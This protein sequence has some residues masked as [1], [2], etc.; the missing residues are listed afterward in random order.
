[1]PN[2]DI[3]FATI[4]NLETGFGTTP[5]QSGDPTT[6][7]RYL[8]NIYDK[9]GYMRDEV[10]AFYIAFILN[11]GS[12]SYAYHIPGRDAV[13]D[14]PANTLT[15][16]WAANNT[17]SELDQ[18]PATSTDLRALSPSNGAVYHFYDTSTYNAS[19]N[20]TST[21]GCRH[22]NFWQNSDEMYPMTDDFETWNA[23]QDL[24][25]NTSNT[26]TDPVTGNVITTSSFDLNRGVNV[27]HHHFPS[28]EN[29]FRRS[30]ISNDSAVNSSVGT[31]STRSRWND[32]L[33]IM[34]DCT[35]TVR[36]EPTAKIRPFRGSC[37][38]INDGNEPDVPDSS[39][40]S[41]SAPMNGS[42]GQYTVQDM[43][44]ALYDFSSG[45]FIADQSMIVRVDWYVAMYKY[46]SAS[47]NSS[48]RTYARLRCTSTNPNNS[49]TGT[50]TV[51]DDSIMNW[52]PNCCN[53]GSTVLQRTD[54]NQAGIRTVYLDPGIHYI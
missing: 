16:T 50:F 48:N 3:F 13:T 44:S 40:S 8:S 18:P 42:Q 15:Y 38:F 17:I 23:E 53:W 27:R 39:T 52:N 49:S 43:A 45:T 5:V 19:F 10:Y 46:N 54:F 14:I 34:T 9:R 31:D 36:N 11:D 37:S 30:I 47:S 2:F 51:S 1:M 29:W 20:T 24:T 33:V 25:D 22:M 32:T 28:N 7:Y 6:A 41:L 26:W 12:M 4:D 35:P 21:G